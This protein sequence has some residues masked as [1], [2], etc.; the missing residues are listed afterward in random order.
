[1]AWRGWWRGWWWL[2]WATFEVSLLLC[3]EAEDDVKEGRLDD[4]EDN[5]D[6]LN[7]AS[8]FKDSRLVGDRNSDITNSSD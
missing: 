1:M 3:Q 8:S 2:Y 7:A 5:L 4:D 6:F